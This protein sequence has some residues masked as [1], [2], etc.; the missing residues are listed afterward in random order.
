MWSD[1]EVKRRGIGSTTI[2]MN[3][4]KMRRMTKLTLSNYMDLFVGNCVPFYFCPRSIMLYKIDK[5]SDPELAYRGGQE[6]V[7]HLVA[8]LRQTVSWAQAHKKRWVFSTS[9]AGSYHFNDYKNLDELTRINWD[10]VR[11]WY[12][13]K[14]MDEKQAE[15]LIES[16][17]PW[18][19]V[20][21]VGVLS[22]KIRDKVSE[23]IQSSSH[24]PPVQVRR[25]WYY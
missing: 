20:S 17:F 5:A 21:R 13:S 8:D 14:C 18:E 16:A 7:V 22:I 11:A 9:N 10:A 23:I 24:R 15:F 25:K 1:A 3:K 6:S 4:I 19:L 12:W 2:G